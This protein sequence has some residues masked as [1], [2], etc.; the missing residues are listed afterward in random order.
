MRQFPI[1]Q[2]VLCAPRGEWK[3]PISF[4]LGERVF[5]VPHV[6]RLFITRRRVHRRPH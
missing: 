2:R 3:A 4:Q 5:V 6:S 1:C